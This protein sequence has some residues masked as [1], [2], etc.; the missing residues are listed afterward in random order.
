MKVILQRV[1]AASVTFENTIVGQINNGIL[2]FLG[3]GK[4]DNQATI[5]KM[6]DKIVTLRIMPD[7]NNKM[8]KSLLDING[9]LLIVSQF[10]LLSDCSHGRRPSFI[11]AGE[12][13]L[14]NRLY[15]SS[16][17]YVKEKYN[18]KVGHGVFGGDMD[19]S[20]TNDG[21]V[22]IILESGVDLW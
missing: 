6:F 15:E 7:E 20:L 10:T 13:G 4:D 16:I 11:N 14:A 17:T 19:V 3:I 21:P 18:L 2:V 8:N 22:T 12:P 5:E 1:K 9:E